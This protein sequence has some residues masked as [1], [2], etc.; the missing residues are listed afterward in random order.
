MSTAYHLQTDGQTKVVNRCLENYL[1]CF[2]GD[3][4]KE[5]VRWLPWAEWWYNTTYHSATK[6]TPFEVVYG[7]P[8]LILP[9]YTTGSS[10]VDQVD[11]VLKDRTKL[12]QLLKDNLTVAQSRMKHQADKHRSDGNSTLVI[13]S[14]SVYSLTAKS[15]SRCV[16][17]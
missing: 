9:T 6:M 13:G 15:P 17:P 1:Q 2:T 16:R 11:R 8:P 3:K 14:S 5:W 7:R 12:L 4:P 10:V